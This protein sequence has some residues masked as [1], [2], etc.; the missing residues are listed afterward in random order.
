[1]TPVSF[2]QQPLRVLVVSQARLLAESLCVALRDRGFLAKHELPTAGLRLTTM[3]SWNPDLVLLEIDFIEDERHRPL[4]EQLWIAPVVLA[5]LGQKI[6]ARTVD[7]CLDA[8]ASIVL[9]MESPLDV[10]VETLQ[11]AVNDRGSA[12]RRTWSQLSTLQKTEANRPQNRAT[13]FDRLTP[14]ERQVLG[15]IIK[16]HSAETIANN[17]WVAVSTVRSQIKSILQKLGVN[18]QVAAVALARQA[19]WTPDETSKPLRPPAG[20][21]RRDGADLLNRL[22]AER[23]ARKLA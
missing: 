2:S 21:D 18:S 6:D 14:R 7:V 3:E 8:G 16:G 5:M 15:E 10:V 9:D 1:M 4:L 11:S 12:E 13:Q 22:D 19:A 17:S 23:F 20:V